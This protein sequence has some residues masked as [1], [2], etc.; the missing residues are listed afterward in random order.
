MQGETVGS[1]GFANAAVT[2]ASEDDLAEKTLGA[3]SN[4]ATAT[5]VDRNVVAQLLEANSRLVK[6]L[7][8]N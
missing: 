6:Q 7:E 8:D 1:Q 3:F 2:K 4:S 5:A